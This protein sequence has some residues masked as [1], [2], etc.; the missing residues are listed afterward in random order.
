MATLHV[1]NV[2]DPLYEALRESAQENGRS[3]GAETISVLMDALAPHNRR[4]LPGFRRRRSGGSLQAFSSAARAVVVDAQAVARAHGQ[5]HVGTE[6]V[7]R[8][9][10]AAGVRFPEGVTEAAVEAALERGEG[11]PSGTIPFSPEAKQALEIAL[12]ESLRSRTGAIEPAD[13]ALGVVRAEGRGAAILAGLGVG[14]TGLRVALMPDFEI[15]GEPE[16][17]VVELTDDWEAQLNELADGYEL[18]QIVERR[19]IFRRR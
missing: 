5:S 17:R 3:I 6:H 8:A 4:T 19:A 1:R 9:L 11:A 12:R 16:F 13:L 7:L 14:S 15:T 18:V 2:P 10:V